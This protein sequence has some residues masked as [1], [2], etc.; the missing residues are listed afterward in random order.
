M[1][2]GRSQRKPG[3]LLPGGRSGAAL[4]GAAPRYEVCVESVGGATS[5]NLDGDRA[6]ASVPMGW[7]SALRH[8]AL[9][10]ELS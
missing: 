9:V 5:H 2:E 1:G 10:G 7:Q 8:R 6:P 3:T 4:S